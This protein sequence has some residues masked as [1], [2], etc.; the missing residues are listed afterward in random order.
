MKKNIMKHFFI[1]IAFLCGSNL[2]AQIACNDMLYVS[3][4]PWACSA[5]ITPDMVLE[6]GPYDYD[7]MTVEPS[8]LTK[9]DLGQTLEYSVTDTE[10]ND[11]CWGQITFEDKTPPVVV[12]AAIATILL[13]DDDCTATVYAE[14]IDNGSYDGCSA[15]TLSPDS[16]SFD[17]SDLGQKDLELT[18]CDELG[19][20]NTATT[21]VNVVSNNCLNKP[22][23]VHAFVTV[24]LDGEQ[25][26][27]LDPKDF[28]TSDHSDFSQ[29]TIS[30]A[31]VDTS[32]VGL[33][34]FV[35][36]NGGYTAW[37]TLQV[38]LESPEITSCDKVIV[39]IPPSRVS[40]MTTDLTSV[41][42]DFN[43]CTDAGFSYSFSGSEY[44]VTS[45]I[46][47]CDDA[48]YPGGLVPD[49]Y[50]LYLY[51]GNSVIDSCENMLQV[52][53][54]AQ[55]CDGIVTSSFL[56]CN[57]FLQVSAN[58]WSCMAELTPEMM[59]EGGP[60]DYTDMY[61]EPAVLTDLNELVTYTVYDP[62][63]D[64]V[65][66]GTVVLEDK[67]P[68]VPIAIQNIVVGLTLDPQGEGRAK[69]FAE[70]VD[71]GSHDGECGP[72]R[73]EPDFWEFTCAD[74]GEATRELT[75][76]DDA[77]GDGFP[78]STAGDNS[79]VTWFTVVVESKL[80]PT[81]ICPQD[82]TIDC[83]LNIYDEA[84]IENVIGS[85]DFLSGCSE[86]GG[87]PQYTDTN[88]YDENGDGDL[89]DEY[90]DADGNTISERYNP[91]CNLGSVTRQWFA[92]PGGCVQ[93]ISIIGEPS[94]SESD[95]TWPD[96]EIDVSC[97]EDETAIPEWNTNTCGL[98]GYSVESDTFLFEN[99]ACTKIINSFKVID[100]CKYD[101]LDPTNVGVYEFTSVVKH[102]DTTVPTLDSPLDFTFNCIGGELEYGITASSA[103][104]SEQMRWI[105]SLDVDGDLS[106]DYIWSSFVEED[107][108][109]A[110]WDDDDGDGVPD[111]RVGNAGNVDNATSPLVTSGEEYR[112][113]LSDDILGTIQGTAR[114]EWKVY[115]LCGNL[116]TEIVN[117]TFN[118]SSSQDLV[119]PTPY[120][121]NAITVT[122]NSTVSAVDFDAGSFDNCTFA[123]NLRFTFSD[124]APEND[125]EFS[126]RSSVMTITGS[127]NQ[128]IP[129]Y[130]WDEAG[131]RD[132]CLANV[133][134]DS[135]CIINE[136]DINWPEQIIEVLT[137]DLSGLGVT[138][139]LLMNTYGFTEDQVLPIVPDCAATIYDYVDTLL[140]GGA[141]TVKILREWTVLDWLASEV[142]TFQQVIK[143][144]NPN[145]YICDF[146]PNTAP[147][148]DCTSG[149]SLDDDVE[150]PA[151]ITIADHR[152]K[153][154][155]LREFSGIP[156]KDSEPIFYNDPASYSATYKDYVHE[157]QVN[158][159]L[160]IVRREWDVT[161]SN[162][163]FS[164]WTFDQFINV[165]LDSILGFV[166][167]TTHGLRPMPQVELVPQVETNDLGIGIID[168]ADTASPSYRDDILNGINIMDLILIQRHILGV[169]LIEDTN[170]LFAGDYTDDG[171]IDGRDMVEIK[172]IIEEIYTGQIDWRFIQDNTVDYDIISNPIF[173]GQKPGDVD[174][175]AELAGHSPVYEN[176]EISYEDRLLNAGENYVVPIYVEDLISGISG[177]EVIFDID[178]TVMEIQDIT[179]GFSGNS[180]SYRINDG[181]LIIIAVEGLPVSTGVDNELFNIRFKALENSTLS[182]SFF[183][184]TRRPSYLVD[185]EFELLT[186]NENIDNPIDTG[187]HDLNGNVISVF[188]NPVIEHLTIDMN[189]YDYNSLRFTLQD[190]TGRALLTE[191][192]KTRIEV[193]HLP[194]GV[195]TYTLNIDNNT[196]TDKLIISK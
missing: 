53:D 104:S 105:V 195:Y 131:N 2:T 149:H 101:P 176:V 161:S 158:P 94:F 44:N 166:S 151:S 190:I 146:L 7:V 175:S 72:V 55:H 51:S 91:A 120:C 86:T 92:G 163:L 52:L 196:Y 112:I 1:C 145:V 191:E 13:D 184:S 132:F 186:T 14:D 130:V 18:V 114:I 38:C 126:G 28:I 45:R 185:N 11:T 87:L 80:E 23:S 57:D 29:M 181:K 56:A 99:D 70:Q 179:A 48:G 102:I 98:V 79:S 121:I 193:S 89:L 17:E 15:I 129:I 36:T 96:A 74:V 21:T 159:L 188:P 106:S 69:V 142:Y 84:T 6:G 111:V 123:S 147:I 139:D 148:G 32:D 103:C 47:D 118:N 59:L 173:I 27:T 35:I 160:L 66:W 143:L 67:T 152:I 65:C 12:N 100:W 81:V 25:T 22:L 135:N 180:L 134:V 3:A 26:L 39:S 73:L 137:T 83:S 174:D 125:P 153:P 95:I 157:L 156:A 119:P 192:A 31:T 141:G 20:C 61:V 82:M 116:S 178:E 113:H 5:T 78:G 115:D 133:V 183:L 16:W 136:D 24:G 8:M 42:T 155:D 37:G 58:P 9:D 189:G 30:P 124:V 88:G 50:T 64:N 122:D 62:K 43:N 108:I 194:S 54:A 4:D 68:P 182:R 40:I 150:W 128:T 177:I 138:P 49:G 93:I 117:L 164:S 85:P 33:H 110:L 168:A 162:A 107:E 60:Y 19:N 170:S 71:N 77:D 46:I 34:T 187:T 63:I 171:V 154:A 167:V 109:D 90:V 144:S 41:V 97:L 165:D 127:G 169:E 140:D 76:Y 10:T 75:V 172:K